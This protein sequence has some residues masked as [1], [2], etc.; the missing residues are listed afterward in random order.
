MS[1]A[2]A[3]RTLGAIAAGGSSWEPLGVR[4]D[5]R[6]GGR[7]LPREADHGADVGRAAGVAQGIPE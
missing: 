4:L 2:Q 1:Q 5:L 6:L 7:E 3:G